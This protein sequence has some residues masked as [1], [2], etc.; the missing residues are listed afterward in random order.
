MRKSRLQQPGTERSKR[1]VV[2]VQSTRGSGA[3]IPSFDM[4]KVTN[5]ILAC[6][7]NEESEQPLEGANIELTMPEVDEWDIKRLNSHIKNMDSVE[8]W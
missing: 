5:A 4:R 2:P 8:F 1:S 7:D 6:L 3:P